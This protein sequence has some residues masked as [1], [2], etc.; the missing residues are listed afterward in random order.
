MVKDLKQKIGWLLALV[1][2]LPVSGALLA[3]FFTGNY[4][5]WKASQGPETTAIVL[6]KSKEK[7]PK[8]GVYSYHAQLA[9]AVSTTDSVTAIADVSRSHFQELRPHSQTRI[10]YDPQNPQRVLLAAEHWFQW[11]SLPI[12]LLSISLLWACRQA[13]SRKTPAGV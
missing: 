1:L 4:A 13:L 3:S 11:E 8:S 10:S 5:T 6:S 7:P 12:L 9:F 2:I